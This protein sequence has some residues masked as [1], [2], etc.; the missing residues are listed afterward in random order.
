MATSA[1][2][3]VTAL[4][5]EADFVDHQPAVQ[6]VPRV[7]RPGSFEG[8][9]QFSDHRQQ[10]AITYNEIFP[11]IKANRLWKGDGHHNA[12]DRVVRVFRR[13]TRCSDTAAATDRRRRAV[14]S[15]SRDVRWFTNIE[16]GRRHEPL[17]LMT[18][19]DNMQV[20]QETHQGSG[21]RDRVPAIRQ[22]STRSKCRS[23]TRSRADYDGVMGVPI[24]FLDK[25]NPDQF[26]ILVNSEDDDADGGL[27]R[28]ARLARSA[29]PTTTPL[30]DTAAN[31]SGRRK[32]F[33][34]YHPR[35][36]VRSSGSLIRHEG[37][38]S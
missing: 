13:T 33:D 25:Y 3:E 26:E 22:L 32:L 4:R 20:Q 16:H 6:P 2:A 1:V 34:V 11:L 19:A 21:R 23:P 8:N 38:V 10:N 7:R 30:A 9:V 15:G 29:S 31:S 35:T 5:D 18:M 37:R 24:T 17:Q 36:H 12:G 28:R 14:T 27:W